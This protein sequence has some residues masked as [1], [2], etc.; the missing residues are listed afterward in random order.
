MSWTSVFDFSSNRS[1]QACGSSPVC[2]SL[3]WHPSLQESCNTM[4]VEKRCRAGI[5]G[6]RQPW[7]IARTTGRS[8]QV[9]L[10]PVDVRYVCTLSSDLRTPITTRN[11]QAGRPESIPIRAGGRC[12][13]QRR[14]W[15][16]RE[17]G[18]DGAKTSV[19]V[20][21]SVAACGCVVR[22]AALGARARPHRKFHISW[23]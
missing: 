1:C 17:C 16:Y 3:F 23:G 20:G 9:R 14:V 5:G 21:Q 12:R 6:S 13:C 15:L 2:T 7:A 22:G 8:G 19:R 18:A 10:L 4:D 11:C